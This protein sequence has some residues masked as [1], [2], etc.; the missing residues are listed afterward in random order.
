[1]QPY[2][3]YQFAARCSLTNCIRLLPVAAL[4]TVSVYCQ[5]QPYQLYQFT[6]RCSHPNFT[7]QPHSHNIQLLCCL[8]QRFTSHQP[9]RLHFPTFHVAS[10]PTFTR[11]TSG[12]SKETWRALRQMW[13]RYD[14]NTVT[15]ASVFSIVSYLRLWVWATVTD[16]GGIRNVA[17]KLV[18]VPAFCAVSLDIVPL[19]CNSPEHD[20][21]VNL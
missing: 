19:R 10:L 3:L 20:L 21:S 16:M 13:R 18:E 5:L 2:Q 7:T 15:F 9:Y 17:Q 8:A 11:R 4:P 14:T 1:M 6:A 12:H